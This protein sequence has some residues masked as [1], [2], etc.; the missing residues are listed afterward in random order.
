MDLDSKCSWIYSLPPDP[1]AKIFTLSAVDN[2]IRTIYF[3]NLIT[4][5]GILEVHILEIYRSAKENL[6]EGVN[7]LDE[8]LEDEN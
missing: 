7:I 4:A 3:T 2:Q 1:L 6:N 5:L 8:M